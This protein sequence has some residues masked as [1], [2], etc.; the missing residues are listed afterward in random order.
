MLTDKLEKDIQREIM[1]LLQ[2]KR[3]WFRRMNTG[4]TQYTDAYGKKRFIRF[5]S[6]GM[7]DLLVWFNNRCWWMEVK[8]KT[9]KQNKNQQIF[10]QEVT[11]AG[12]VYIVVRGVAD[13]IKEF[14]LG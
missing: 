6:K 11:Q 12:M 9:G 5:G 2:Y 3:I 14:K 10:Q 13:V 4:A 7:A 8:T 1:Q